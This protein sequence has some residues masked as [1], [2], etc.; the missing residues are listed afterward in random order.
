M[1]LKPQVTPNATLTGEAAPVWWLGTAEVLW[2]SIAGPPRHDTARGADDLG[3][4]ACRPDA[5]QCEEGA[6]EA[7]ELRQEVQRYRGPKGYQEVPLQ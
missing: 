2:D 7:C 6:G 3:A 5:V 1:S 4:G